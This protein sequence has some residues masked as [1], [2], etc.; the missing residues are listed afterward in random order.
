MKNVKLSLMLVGVAFLLLLLCGCGSG[1]E[2]SNPS[3]VTA[4]SGASSSKF[5]YSIT[6]QK[7]GS[8]V[9]NASVIGITQDDEEVIADCDAGGN[10]DLASDKPIVTIVGMAPGMTGSVEVIDQQHTKIHLS[11]VPEPS[12][13]TDTDTTDSLQK[14]LEK[15]TKCVMHRVQSTNKD[16]DVK[17]KYKGDFLK[18]G[19]NK[20]L[21]TLGKKEYSPDPNKW[22]KDTISDFKPDKGKKLYVPTRYRKTFKVIYLGANISDFL[23][24]YSDE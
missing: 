6:V 1:E 23:V 8:P 18:F 17:F 19:C 13:I 9:A 3:A 12:V 24:L 11:N 20:W 15:K 10:V 2:S 4:D 21:P 14:E 16:G 7:E 22:D 5:V